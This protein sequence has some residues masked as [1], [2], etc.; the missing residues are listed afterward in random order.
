M[1]NGVMN[2][3][4]HLHFRCLGTFAFRGAGDWVSGPPF[5]RGRELLEY[6]ASHPR[7]AASRTT[8]AEAFWPD[9]DGDT[10]AHRLHLAVS[11]ARAALREVLPEV[12]AIQTIALGSYG[13]HPA[14]RI[15]SDYEILFECYQDASADAMRRGVDLYR[16]EFLAGESA[17]WMHAMRVRCGAIYITMLERLTHHAIAEGDFAEGLNLGLQVLATDR[18]HEGVTRL[19]MRC[20]A[21]TGRRSSALDEYETLR[22]YLRQ[23]LEVNPSRA[24]QELRAEILSV[25]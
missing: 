19:V 17:D 5:K 1:N 10:I 7:S 8:L 25:M 3:T 6:L 18:A 22:R 14:L 4:D 12:D 9:A 23:H 11:G 13:W 20:F 21:E 2:A 16:G 24:T 15:R